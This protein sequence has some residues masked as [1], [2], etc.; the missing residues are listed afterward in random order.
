MRSR[1]P[2]R[3]ALL[4]GCV[5]ATAA[6]GC[7]F[8]GGGVAGD[9]AT[10]DDAPD[11]PPGDRD[12]DGVADGADNCPDVAN[13]RQEDEDGDGVGN[14][15]DNCPHVANADQANDGETVAGVTP[16]NAG[17][18]CDPS[19]SGPGNDIIFFDGFDDAASLSSWTTV[20][21][22]WTISGGALRVSPAPGVAWAYLRTAQFTGTA[23]ATA[24]TLTDVPP[25]SSAA[26][27]NRAIGSLVGF[28]P[29]A[30]TGAGYLC[31]AYS[32]PASATP[33]SGTLNLITLRGAQPLQVED[34]DFL[35]DDLQE[36]ETYALTE[37]LD[38]ATRD[39]TCRVASTALPMPVSL[40]GSDNAFDTGFIGLRVQYVAAS[41][42][43]VVVFAIPQG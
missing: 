2:A 37:S 38:P 1:L 12:G 32:N 29:G 33:P 26:D 42:P 34:V 40:A 41:F 3:R 27:T 22:N 14:A 31:L 24:A 43:Y 6:A 25:S 5:L 10:S 36:G 4:L 28:S 30:G 21:G 23:L 39:L 11:G 7:S 13:R 8:D 9:A 20:G 35:D 18:A 17:D 16:D 15:C 19:P